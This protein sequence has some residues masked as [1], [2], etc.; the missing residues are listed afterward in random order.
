MSQHGLVWELLIIKKNL[1]DKAIQCYEKAVEIDP[2]YVSTWISMGIA[3]ESK[4]EYDKA[5]E[6]YEKALELDPNHVSAWYRMGIAYS[7]KKEYNKAIECY[8]KSLELDPNYI[9]A[10]IDMKDAKEEHR[11]NKL[12]QLFRELQ[13]IL[14]EKYPDFDLTNYKNFLKSGVI[15]VPEDFISVIEKL[16]VLSIIPL[17]I[18]STIRETILELG[19]KYNRL[20][21]AEIAEKCGEPEDCIIVVTHD[22]IENKD[23]YAEFFKS[24]KSLVFDQQANIEEIDKLM[25]QYRQW[26]KEGISKK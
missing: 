1:Y 21:I 25:D 15:E 24:T 16:D 8:E 5:I 6:C 17:S 9:F 12:Y 14:R 26:E 11:R 20:Q 4:K 13:S 7:D 18:Q 3:Y 23:I 10:W 2:N 19:V 22:M